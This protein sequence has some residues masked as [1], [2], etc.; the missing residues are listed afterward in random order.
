MIHH[1]RVLVSGNLAIL[2]L[3]P[4]AFRPCFTTSLAQQIIFKISLYYNSL[5]IGDNRLK[6]S[7]MISNPKHTFKIWKIYTAILKIVV[8]THLHGEV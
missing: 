6:K 1:P 7:L 8:Q 4:M 3:R 5:I 2:K